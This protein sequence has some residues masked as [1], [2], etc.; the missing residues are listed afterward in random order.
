MQWEVLTPFYKSH[1]NFHFISRKILG[2]NAN[3][4]RHS[5][6]QCSE[7]IVWQ[8]FCGRSSKP[9][10]SPSY[11]ILG[12]HRDY[13]YKFL[14]WFYNTEEKGRIWQKGEKRK[15]IWINGYK[16]TKNNLQII[17]KPPIGPECHKHV[18]DS[19]LTALWPISLWSLQIHG[20]WADRSRAR[21]NV[22]EG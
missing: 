2:V 22:G 17:P 15:L 21:V 18:P 6:G 14:T 9:V 1:G 3:D 8:R 20:W 12:N 13:M 19:R 7:V 10:W 11:L 5:T 16:K 4:Q